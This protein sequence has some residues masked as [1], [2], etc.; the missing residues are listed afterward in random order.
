[1]KK[2]M[3]ALRGLLLAFCLCCVLGFIGCGG[4]NASDFVIKINEIEVHVDDTVQDLLDQGLVICETDD[5]VI[6]ESEYPTL[7]AK[8]MVTK[9][10]FIGAEV[11]GKVEC[12]HIAVCPYNNSGKEVSL[13]DCQI[14]TIRF[15]GTKKDVVPIEINGV[16]PYEATP[17]EFLNAFDQSE[18]TLYEDEDEKSKFIAGDEYSTISTF[19]GDATYKAI[20]GTYTVDVDDYLLDEKKRT[21]DEE[22]YEAARKEA[23]KTIHIT[24]FSIE[25]KLDVKV[26]Y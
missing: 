9:G 16:D 6:S 17:E 15:Y 19:A 22:A 23:A 10:Y 8:E 26:E 18:L 1:M 13:A 14:H 12:S 25:K 20:T 4:P 3:V 21:V 2:K 5:S 24:E 7:D 11:D